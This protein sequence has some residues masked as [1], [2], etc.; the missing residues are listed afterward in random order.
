[1]ELLSSFSAEERG[2]LGQ[3]LYFSMEIFSYILICCL[4]RDVG[5]F[6]MNVIFLG[7]TEMKRNIV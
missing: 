3:V 6:G 7:V 2:F 5:F 1:M 4:N